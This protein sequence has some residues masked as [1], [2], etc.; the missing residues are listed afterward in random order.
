MPR[1]PI[2][3]GSEEGYPVYE[4]DKEVEG[5]GYMAGP[6]ESQQIEDIIE[7]RRQERE[8]AEDIAEDEADYAKDVEKA[9]VEEAPPQRPMG[10]GEPI[11]LYIKTGLG[12]FTV[13]E[14][15]FGSRI[16]AGQFAEQNFPD[17]AYKTMSEAEIKVYIQAQEDKQ[18]K[19]TERKERRT[20]RV[21]KVKGKLKEGAEKV[22]KGFGKGLEKAIHGVT[23]EP[24]PRIRRAT[25]PARAPVRQPRVRRPGVSEYAGQATGAFLEA[26]RDVAGTHGMTRETMEPEIR[27]AW[28]VE[29]RPR[30]RAPYRPP[31]PPR[32]RMGAPPQQR[33]K[34]YIPPGGGVFG[35][36][37][38]QRRAIGQPPRQRT[39]IPRPPQQR[40]RMNFGGGLHSAKLHMITPRGITQ[41]GMYRRQPAPAPAPAPVKKTPTKKKK[42]KKSKKK[43]K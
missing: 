28:G 4:A 35:R 21:E 19:R 39:N 17:K 34:I 1:K 2:V 32:S 31:G 23:R 3:P 40:S 43:G 25:A 33:P 30:Q 36:P 38:Q 6:E 7:R 15:V 9:R 37:S 24:A 42:R 11:Y 5:E 12:T 10:T 16:E 22:E 27:Q 26:S 14:R 29:G 8:T 41:P 18:V 20:E 13:V